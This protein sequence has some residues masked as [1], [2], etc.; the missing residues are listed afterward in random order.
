MSAWQVVKPMVENKITTPSPRLTNREAVEGVVEVGWSLGAISSRGI[1]MI[2]NQLSH[3]YTPS[4][5]AR[6]SVTQA[7]LLRSV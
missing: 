4:P 7:R 2:G 6:R 1:P 3:E 5:C